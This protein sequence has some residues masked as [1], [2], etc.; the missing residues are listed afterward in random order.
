MGKDIGTGE[1]AGA[2]PAGYEA[3]LKDLEAVIGDE[4]DF[5]ANA[6]NTAALL[7]RSL[8]DV[9]WVGW[10]F[11]KGGE[12][13]LGPF[14]GGPARSRIRL[15]RGVC[16]VCAAERRSV[17]VPDVRRFPG[18]IACDSA[19]SAE[20]V[21][22]VTSGGRLIG[23]LDIDSPTMGRFDEADAQGLAALVAFVLHRSDVRGIDGET[24][25]K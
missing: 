14:Q 20:I 21:V 2:I 10:Y 11:D 5:V 4:R 3:I 13:V 7:S 22:P 8:D 15:G 12:L 1:S 16:G 9:S 18:H 24:S 17:I 25:G 23:V 19:A 6:A